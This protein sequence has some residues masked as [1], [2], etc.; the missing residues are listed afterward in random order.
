MKMSWRMASGLTVN[1]LV[2]LC[3]FFNTLH[4]PCPWMTSETQFQMQKTNIQTRAID[5]GLQILRPPNSG[6]P[7]FWGPQFPGPP[8]PKASKIPGPLILVTPK[9][10]GQCPCF[11][12][13]YL[14]APQELLKPLALALAHAKTTET[15]EVLL[16]STPLWLKA[17]VIKY[18]TSWSN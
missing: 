15:C 12:Y 4:P 5:R 17:I 18:P 2:R 16:K 3:I 10:Q 7:K 1:W 9:S 8:N 13:L 11:T 14:G 6:A